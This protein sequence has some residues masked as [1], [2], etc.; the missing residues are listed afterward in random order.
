M[1][2]TLKDFIDD[3][4]SESEN[5]LKILHC[6]DPARKSLKINQEIRSM[7]RI[8]WHLVQTL[9]EMISKC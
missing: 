6:I 4:R 7:E 5:T 9:S 3:Y 1:Y 8:A 2:R